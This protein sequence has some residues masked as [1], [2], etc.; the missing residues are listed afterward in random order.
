MHARGAAQEFER[1]GPVP[2]GVHLIVHPQ[3]VLQ[4]KQN[5]RFIVD[6]HQHRFDLRARRVGLIVL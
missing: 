6:D 4:C 3:Q 2:E 1:I 5:V